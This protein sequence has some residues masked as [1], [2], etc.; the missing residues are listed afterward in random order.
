[1]CPL[2]FCKFVK[3]VYRV[4][5]SCMNVFAGRQRKWEKKTNAWIFTIT[6]VDFKKGLWYNK[7]KLPQSA[8]FG[9]IV[10]LWSAFS[11]VTEPA[12]C[13]AGSSSRLCRRVVRFSLRQPGM[14]CWNGYG[15]PWKRALLCIRK[16][17]IR[18]NRAVW[19]CERC[20]GRALSLYIPSKTRKR[21]YW[22]QDPIPRLHRISCR[23][24]SVLTA[25][26]TFFPTCIF[27]IMSIGDC[28]I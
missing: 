24:Q 16:T 13:K 6:P 20:F 9:D 10:G 14:H 17:D 27:S 12:A 4:G 8:L 26:I 21:E 7:N 23:L 1:M 28:V 25:I 19:A 15:M 5:C 22:W 3:T 18:R 2:Y 11:A